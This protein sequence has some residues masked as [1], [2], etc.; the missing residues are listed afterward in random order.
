MIKPSGETVLL[1]NMDN[2]KSRKL[3]MLMIRMGMRIR[4]VDKED[5]GSPVGLLAGLKEIT[6]E[7][8]HAE[9]MDFN[10]EMMI[11]RGFTNVRLDLFLQAMRKEGIGR[12][13]YKAI[14]TPTNARWNS[15]QLYQELKQEHEEMT[16]AKSE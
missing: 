16:Q 3:K 4:M 14:L 6:L 10:D 12:I 9:V 15:W 5:Y 11:L 13:N 1:Y 7:D 8:P 2:E